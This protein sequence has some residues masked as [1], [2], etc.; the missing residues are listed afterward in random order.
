MSQ[1]AIVR[2][3]VMVW[4][5]VMAMSTT[6]INSYRKCEI[7]RVPIH[8]SMC[9]M[10]GLDC[11]IKRYEEEKVRFAS[12]VRES[13]TSALERLRHW[14]VLL[15]KLPFD[16]VSRRRMTSIVLSGGNQSETFF[17]NKIKIL[18]IINRHYLE[19][20]ECNHCI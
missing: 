11:Y 17:G 8:H 5:T 19:Q 2:A 13:V 4:D 20:D 14:L 18:L 9:N 12:F 16:S 7:W 3:S 10:H 6:R 1:R 15:V